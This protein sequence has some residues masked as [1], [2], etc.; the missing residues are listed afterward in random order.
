MHV[1]ERSGDSLEHP[2]SEDADAAY[3]DRRIDGLQASERF[4]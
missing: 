1:E 3:A 4:R 2:L